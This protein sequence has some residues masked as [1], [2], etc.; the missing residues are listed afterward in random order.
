MSITMIDNSLCDSNFAEGVTSAGIISYISALRDYGISYNE[1]TPE[2]LSLLPESHDCGGIIL[3]IRDKSELA[4]ANSRRFGYVCIPEELWQHARRID[5]PVMLECEPHGSDFLLYTIE[6][7]SR[8]NCRNISLL[9][10]KDDFDID[11]L[12]FA[13]RLALYKRESMIPMDICPT[14]GK[15]T[16]VS[17]LISAAAAGADSVTMRF[18]SFGEYAELEDSAAAMAA[19]FMVP[20]PEETTK[21]L[22]ACEM[23]Y[24]MLYGREAAGILRRAVKDDL[25]V[26]YNFNAEL[27]AHLDYR[28]L[29]ELTVAARHRDEGSLVYK[30]LKS[31]NVE[32]K[33]AKDLEKVLDELCMKLFDEGENNG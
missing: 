31:L 32:T 16:A 23:L 9:R 17:T 29:A 25:M 33:D 21:A 3:R 13:G 1:I 28:R 27:P 19:M 11:G 2:T 12:R 10:I 20:M 14:D 24:Y 30:Q 7:N 6:L 15:L 18:G 22:L 8:I 5:S 26:P 4:A